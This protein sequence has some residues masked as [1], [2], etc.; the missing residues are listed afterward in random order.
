M[1]QGNTTNTFSLSYT[2]WSWHTLLEPAVLTLPPSSL[3]TVKVYVTVPV[4]AT[5]ETYSTTLQ[6]TGHESIAHVLL[7]VQVRYQSY[8]PVM[9]RRR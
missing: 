9:L 2:G 5:I 6:A 3:G 4:T 1:N 7:S 8:L